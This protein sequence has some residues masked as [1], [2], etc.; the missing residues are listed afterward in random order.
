MDEP[1]DDYIKEIGN[2]EENETDKKEK[3]EINKR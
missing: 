1:Y 2:E 3:R